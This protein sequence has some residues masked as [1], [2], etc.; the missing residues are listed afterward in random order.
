MVFDMPANAPTP[1]TFRLGT[2]LRE[3]REAV[4]MGQRELAEL[5]GLHHTVVSKIENGHRVPTTEQTATML[6]YLNV[7]GE[8]ADAIIALARRTDDPVWIAV[9]LPEQQHQMEAFLDLERNAKTITEVSPL[10]VPGLLQTT[11]YIRGIMSIAV[12]AKEVETRTAVRIG[13]RETIT[14]DHNPVEFVA[15]IGE[16]ALRQI[17]GDIQIMIEQLCYLLRMAERPNIELRVVP[18][19]SGWRPALEGAFTLFEQD[20]KTVIHLENRR[21]GLFLHMPGDVELYREAVK[22]ERRVAMSQDESTQFI[23]ELIN[24]MESQ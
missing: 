8:R 17:V 23:T 7:N 10:L 19:S 6:A 9:T 5:V 11:D 13:R 21:S 1:K 2:A 4:G 3:A 14:R 22:W 15:L 12:T 24:Q 16:G 20:G 18:Y